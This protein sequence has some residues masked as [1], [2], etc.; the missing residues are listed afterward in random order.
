MIK[1]TEELKIRK[2]TGF[3]RV[4]EMDLGDNFGCMSEFISQNP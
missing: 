4:I 2:W 1:K 3:V